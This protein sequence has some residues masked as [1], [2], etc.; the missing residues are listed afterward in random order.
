MAASSCAGKKLSGLTSF[1]WA[2][3]M[4]ISSRLIS[5][6]CTLSEYWTLLTTC[7]KKSES[8]AIMLFDFFHMSTVV[9]VITRG[10]EVETSIFYSNSVRCLDVTWMHFLQSECMF[11]TFLVKW[12]QLAVNTGAVYFSKNYWLHYL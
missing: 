3:Q 2:N 4:P 1:W 8:S 9:S 10:Y 11:C 6:F 7:S 12:F 5:P